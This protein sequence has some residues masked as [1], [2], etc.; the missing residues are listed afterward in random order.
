M[1]WGIHHACDAAGV[2][3]RRV[4]VTYYSYNVSLDAKQCKG[5][6]ADVDAIRQDMRYM[7]QYLC[8]RKKGQT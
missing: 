6:G 5:L 3:E 2:A 1:S 4:V 8:A 7:H